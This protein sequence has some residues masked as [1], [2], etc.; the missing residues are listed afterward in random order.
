MIIL[1]QHHIAEAAPMIR[2]PTDPHR[3][4][5]EE[6]PSRRRLAGIEHCYSVSRIDNSTHTGGNA[7][8]ALQKIQDDSLSREEVPSRTRKPNERGFR[9][10]PRSLRH[11]RLNRDFPAEL[12]ENNSDERHTTHDER[13]PRHH[14]CPPAVLRIYRQ[15]CGD[16]S[17]RQV[18]LDGKT[19]EP[20]HTRRVKQKI[21]RHTVAFYLFFHRDN[22]PSTDRTHEILATRDTR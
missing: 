18:L 4:F 11:N 7:G 19:D 17:R 21:T 20:T 15:R 14:G 2:S 1:H 12:A 16:I 22:P 5:L 9:R 3:I 13:F 8:E 10:H 6:P